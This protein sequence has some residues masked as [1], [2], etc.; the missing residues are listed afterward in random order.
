MSQAAV[1]VKIED[2]P[3]GERIAR[4]TVDNARQ[5]QLPVDDG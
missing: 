3:G 5:A 4:V 1:H 2:R